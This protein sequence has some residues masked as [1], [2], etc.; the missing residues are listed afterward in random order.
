ALLSIGKSNTE[1][2]AELTLSLST[3]KFHVSNILS[4]LEANSR[5]EAVSIARR[6][7]LIE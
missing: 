5:G 2:S 6:N 1:I 3:I 7:H 4:K